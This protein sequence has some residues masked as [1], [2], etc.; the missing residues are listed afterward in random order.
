M[1]GCT[2]ASNSLGILVLGIAASALVPPT[3]PFLSTR[4][5][6]ERSR[7]LNAEDSCTPGLPSWALRFRSLQI[8]RGGIRDEGLQASSSLGG[9][10]L[11]SMAYSSDQRH[12][13]AAL[14]NRAFIAQE[15][16]K[17][18]KD[19][20]VGEGPGHVLE[21]SSGT[22][23]HVEAFA[24][25]LPGWVF[26]PTEVRVMRCGAHASSTTCLVPKPSARHAIHDGE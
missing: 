24:K 6:A 25:S 22:G 8:L 7:S 20:D 23:C 21:I 4:N 5:L 3:Q 16:T 18:V 26:L 10:K 15:V 17:W 1:T 9:V 13:P 12:V 2:R 19:V 14:R 11:P